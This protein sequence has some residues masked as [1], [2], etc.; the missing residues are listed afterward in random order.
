L[1]FTFRTG[2]V[3]PA[4]GGSHAVWPSAN[5]GRAQALI[6]A[7]GFWGKGAPNIRIRNF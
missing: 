6:F 4:P 2:V 1:S 5:G 7:D 3:N